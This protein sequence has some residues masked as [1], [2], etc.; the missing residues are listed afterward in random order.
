MYYTR[1]EAITRHPDEIT[2]CRPDSRCS[3]YTP[4]DCYCLSLIRIWRC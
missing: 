3:Y 1:R 2:P 4:W